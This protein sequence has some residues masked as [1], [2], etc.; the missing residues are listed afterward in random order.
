MNRSAHWEPCK[1]LKVKRY[2]E[3]GKKLNFAK[4]FSIFPQKRFFKNFFSRIFD[5][6]GSNDRNGQKRVL[7]AYPEGW[8]LKSTE[9]LT[10]FW[11][12]WA[13][14]F[15][16]PE[17]GKKSD[18]R[19][20]KF[21]ARKMGEYV[22]MARGSCGTQKVDLFEVKSWKQWK[23]LPKMDNFEEIILNKSTFWAHISLGKSVPGVCVG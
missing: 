1:G 11:G 5:F 2:W 4:K 15:Q 8:K 23:K 6:F 20:R 10:D 3:I 16:G 22:G 13:L 14:F 9:Y 7:A 21:D 19:G 17:N 12:V 18:P